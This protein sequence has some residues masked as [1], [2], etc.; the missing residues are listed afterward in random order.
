[1]ILGLVHVGKIN[2]LGAYKNKGGYYCDVRCL[3]AHVAVIGAV[4]GG[5]AIDLRWVD[6]HIAAFDTELKADAVFNANCAH[7]KTEIFDQPQT[8]EITGDGHV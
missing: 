7:W 5:T 3:K 1:M 4:S 6:S 2:C 8:T